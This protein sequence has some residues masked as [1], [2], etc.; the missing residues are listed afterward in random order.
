M[1][2]PARIVDRDGLSG[3][4]L[5]DEHKC[6]VSLRVDAFDSVLDAERFLFW[7]GGVIGRDV[8][9][10]EGLIRTWRRER[11]WPVCTESGCHER[12]EDGGLCECCERDAEEAGSAQP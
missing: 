4:V 6:P 12:V 1:I 5:L 11:Y 8:L 10:L 3:V 7:S 9:R 2:T